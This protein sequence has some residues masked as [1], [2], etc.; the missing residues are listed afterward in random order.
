MMKVLGFTTLGPA[1]ILTLIDR[2]RFRVFAVDDKAI[3]DP[4]WK[5]PQKIDERVTAFCIIGPEPEMLFDQVQEK[6]SSSGLERLMYLLF[7]PEPS[8]LA[9]VKGLK[10]FDAEP[11]P[12][13]EWIKQRRTFKDVEVELERDVKPVETGAVPDR[14]IPKSA[15]QVVQDEVKQEIGGTFTYLLNDIAKPVKVVSTAGKVRRVACCYVSGVYGGNKMRTIFA[16]MVEDKKVPEGIPARLMEY[17]KT[18]SGKR[19][20]AAFHSHYTGGQSLRE[21]SEEWTAN[22]SD[23]EYVTQVILGSPQV[24]VT[25]V[26]TPVLLKEAASNGKEK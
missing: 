17:R 20:H 12:G 13:G 5:V 18:D 1:S 19:L 24:K 8:K 7:H 9:A 2:N 23:L 3:A 22:Q 4:N 26:R 15:E 10:M 6:I 21:A 11:G 16:K 25:R 14:M